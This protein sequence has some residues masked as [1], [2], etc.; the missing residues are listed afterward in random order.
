[1]SFRK[2]KEDQ[3]ISAA[4]LL[5]FD[6]EYGP[7]SLQRIAV[8]D[9]IL[10][11]L[12]EVMRELKGRR[13][14]VFAFTSGLE[15]DGIP[16]GSHHTGRDEVY[17][18]YKRM[19]EKQAA[20]T[21]SEL[22]SG[23]SAAAGKLVASYSNW[24]KYSVPATVRLIDR[25]YELGVTADKARRLVEQHYIDRLARIDHNYDYLFFWEPPTGAGVA[26][27]CQNGKI[28]RV[29]WKEDYLALEPTVER[30]YIIIRARNKTAGIA[31]VNKFKG[32]VK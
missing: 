26:F 22:F 10:E 14:S 18:Q 11:M 30:Q 9:M 8:E 21:K 1:M 2:L 15:I 7:I 25:R 3:E 32:V 24:S 4:A 28:P 13:M 27:E 6:E 5:A 20:R 19:A 23:V 16:I 31:I 29:F 17:A 12:Q